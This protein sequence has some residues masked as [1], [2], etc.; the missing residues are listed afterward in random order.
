LL[1]HRSFLGRPSLQRI[2]PREATPAEDQCLLV[3]TNL[4]K[5]VSCWFLI[6]PVTNILAGSTALQ[7]IAGKGK[8]LTV[9][10]RA[11]DDP[12]ACQKSACCLNWRA[13]WEAHAKKVEEAVL[14]HSD[15]HT[16]C[17]SSQAEQQVLVATVRDLQMQRSKNR[18]TSFT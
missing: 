4:E 12:G 17:K 6:N 10:H 3:L 16:H 7:A 15:A 2:N 18:K 5:P 1:V 14:E 13:D 9:L 11:W 8:S